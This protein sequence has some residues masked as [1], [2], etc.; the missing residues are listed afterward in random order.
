MVE[1]KVVV[2]DEIAE[3]LAERAR[4]AHITP[5]QLA[6][7]AVSAYLGSATKP[8]TTR[9][10]FVALGASGRSDISE[11]AEEILRAGLGA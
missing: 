1:L 2:S 5:E 8:A 6:S 10:G 9:P 7:D 4:E 3:S 11:H